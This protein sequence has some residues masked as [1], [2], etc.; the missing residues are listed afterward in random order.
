MKRNQNGTSPRIVTVQQTQKFQIWDE[1]EVGMQEAQPTAGRLRR[2]K[3]RVG[4]S[5]RA[6]Q[7]ERQRTNWE[8]AVAV[9]GASHPGC[10]ASQSARRF[11][12]PLGAPHQWRAAVWVPGSICPTPGL[13]IAQKVEQL[14]WSRAKLVVRESLATCL[15]LC[16]DAYSSSNIK[17]L[18]RCCCW[19]W[20]CGEPVC[21]SRNG[22]APR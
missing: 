20:Q 16:Q 1:V 17:L 12:A 10:A 3:R 7:D 14:Q 9:A 5:E 19:G 18:S 11:G 22:K 8:Q 15:K 13:S 4:D 6:R 21:C 2:L